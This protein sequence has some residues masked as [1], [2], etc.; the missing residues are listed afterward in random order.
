MDIKSCAIGESIQKDLHFAAD[1]SLKDDFLSGTL[2]FRPLVTRLRCQ[3][4]VCSCLP[5]APELEQGGL[6]CMTLKA[7]PLTKEDKQ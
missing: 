1:R 5:F 6:H 7:L 2:P 3:Q 4:G